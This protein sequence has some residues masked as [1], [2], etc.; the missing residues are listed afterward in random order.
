M[1]NQEHILLSQIFLHVWRDE[2]DLTLPQFI[3]FTQ[4]SPSKCVGVFDCALHM[5]G[6]DAHED[7]SEMKLP[8]TLNPI[9]E[10]WG[11]WTY[12]HVSKTHPDANL[13][14]LLAKSLTDQMKCFSTP[15]SSLLPAMPGQMRRKQNGLP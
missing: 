13:H 5:L 4:D 2:E 12:Q 8:A 9:K 10:V 3:D 6:E 14:E 15:S 11:A 1:Q 7:F